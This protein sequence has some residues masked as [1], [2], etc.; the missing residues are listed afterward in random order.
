MAFNEELDFIIQE[1]LDAG[2]QRS[3]AYRGGIHVEGAADSVYEAVLDEICELWP[4]LD[5]LGEEYEGLKEQVAVLLGENSEFTNKIKDL[6]KEVREWHARY[7][8]LC[9]FGCRYEPHCEYCK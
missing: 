1:I 5:S 2:W 8:E 7:A 3:M 4:R 9:D 6:S